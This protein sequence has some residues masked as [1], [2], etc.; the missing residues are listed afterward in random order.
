MCGID[1]YIELK[2][3]RDILRVGVWIMVDNEIFRLSKKKLVLTVKG[4]ILREWA[5]KW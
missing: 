3:G 1:V 2:A 4:I 5:H